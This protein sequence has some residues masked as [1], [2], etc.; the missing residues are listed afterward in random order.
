MMYLLARSETPIEQLL[1][2]Y[3]ATRGIGAVEKIGLS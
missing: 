2:G 3:L 1:T